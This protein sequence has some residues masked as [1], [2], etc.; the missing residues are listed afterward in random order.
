MGRS[1]DGDDAAVVH[2]VVIRAHQHQVG[3][4]GFAAVFP[5]LDVVGVQ[6]AGGSAAGNHAAAVAVLQRA[7]QPPVDQPGLSSRADELA[8]P[9]EPHL[10][11]GVAGHILALGVGEQRPQMQRGDPVFHVHVHHHGG[12]LPVRAAGSVGVPP[13]LDQ[14]HERLASAG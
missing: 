7:A 9:F 4:L 10:A 12:V 2:P 11:G 1:G 5:V 3:Q 8:V 6:A 13:G 14:P